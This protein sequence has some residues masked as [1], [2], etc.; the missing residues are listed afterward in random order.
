MLIYFKNW[1]LTSNLFQDKEAS[2]N[3]Y[4][5]GSCWIND[6]LYR[7]FVTRLANPLYERKSWHAR[8]Y[9]ITHKAERYL[10]LFPFFI[11]SSHHLFTHTFILYTYKFFLIIIIFP[12]S[13]VF[14][15]RRHVYR[16]IHS[17][18]KPAIRTSWFHL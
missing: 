9:R 4:D 15:F 11:H 12:V 14:F 8:L 6:D 5:E 1:I 10:F 7:Q 16:I 13:T 17:F 3:R 18:Y 2:E